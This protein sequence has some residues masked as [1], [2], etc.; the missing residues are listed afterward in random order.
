[1]GECPRG[2]LGGVFGGVCW[3]FGGVRVCGLLACVC[4]VWGVFGGVFE[5]VGQGLGCRF[6]CYYQ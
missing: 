5:G 4:V 6:C 1:M 2:G 3:C